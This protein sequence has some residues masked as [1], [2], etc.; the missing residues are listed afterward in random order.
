MS[1]LDS[2]TINIDYLLIGPGNPVITGSGPW[3]ITTNILDIPASTGTIIVKYGS[4]GQAAGVT[5]SSSATTHTF[6]TQSKIATN[7]KNNLVSIGT[8]PTITLSAGPT[9]GQLMRHG[10]W[11]SNSGNFV[12][13]PFTF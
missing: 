13:Q 3:T 4:G 7:P 9:L 6:T 5:N 12:K 8:S 2:R 1:S 11:F 10:K